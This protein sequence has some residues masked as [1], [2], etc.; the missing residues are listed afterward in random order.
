MIELI[1]V[2]ASGIFGLTGTVFSL[3]KSRQLTA[4]KK[5]FA[6]QKAHQT[7]LEIRMA[8]IDARR[9]TEASNDEL[10]RG[11]IEMQKM[12]LQSNSEALTESL[13]RLVAVTEKGQAD[14]LMA[15]KSEMNLARGEM[16]I[17]SKDA[18][19]TMQQVHTDMQTVP[20]E[21][22][23]LLNE[24]FKQVPE[25]TAAIILPELSAVRAQL[26]K[27]I[28]DVNRNKI[29]DCKKRLV[30]IEKAVNQLKVM[31]EEA[32]KLNVIDL[33][34]NTKRPAIVTGEMGNQ[35][36]KDTERE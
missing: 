8:E 26:E 27:V 4:Q 32:P 25:N 5:Q 14:L 33:N 10:M 16:A 17:S 36:T 9:E 34:N 24:S 13:G 23:R 31:K 11:F 19:E 2:V 22:V 3:L 28:T 20:S 7:T 12:L 1:V 15:F 18:R 29:D 21:T 6:T 35:T 30:N